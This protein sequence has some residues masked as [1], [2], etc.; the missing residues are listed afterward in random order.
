MPVAPAATPDRKMPVAPAATPDRKMP[1]APAATLDRRIHQRLQESAGALARSVTGGA[2]AGSPGILVANPSS[3]GRRLCVDVSSLDALPEVSDPVH[4]AGQWEGRKTAVVDVPPM[5]FAWIGPTA[6]AAAKAPARKWGIFH[7][8]PGDPPPLAELGTAENAASGRGGEAVGATLRNDLFEL[9][10]DKATGAIRAIFDYRHRGPRFAQQLGMRLA[11]ASG[12]DDDAY[13]IMVADAI[14]IASP[15]PVVGEAVVRGRLLD[16]SARR[17]AGFKQTTR[18]CRGSRVIEL[19]IE[20]DVTEPPGPE[21]WGSYYAA[22]FAW[23]DETASLYRAVNQAVVETEAAML[24]SPH[25]VEVRREQQRTA[26][27]AGGLP[28][29]RRV[30][31]RKLD[32]LL[33]VRGETARRFRLGMGIDLPQP[34]VAAMD[35]LVPAIVTDGRSRPAHP[36][37]WLFHLDVRGV[38]A[39]HWEPWM[40]DGRADGFRVR[41]LETEG[42]HVALGLRSFRPVRSAWRIDTIDHVPQDLATEG[43]RIAIDLR[44][45]E[46]T[47][48]EARFG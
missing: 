16:R 22:R 36:S 47:E 35:F 11:G 13:S 32:T 38:V 6:E 25:F 8:G 24:E 7:R 44:P 29:H 23:A 33:V 48:V 17:L 39:T 1:V 4:A 21:P 28:Y 46:W 10:I 27:L 5:G 34:L 40:I 43:D 20:L 42:R 18:V 2:T 41:L 3:S 37:A 26:V 9:T 14:E 45:Y 15:G 30:G 31:L 12:D 19:D